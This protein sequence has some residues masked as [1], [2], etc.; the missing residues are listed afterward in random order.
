MD[1]NTLTDSTSSATFRIGIFL[2]AISAVIGYTT[3]LESSGANVAWFAFSNI[4][5]LCGGIALV[6]GP[7]GGKNYLFWVGLL[8][9]SA[10]SYRILSLAWDVISRIA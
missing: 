5:L 2:I 8:A 9:V 10:A 6:R 3:G 4:G 1:S 7:N